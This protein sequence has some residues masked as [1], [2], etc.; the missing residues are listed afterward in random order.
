MDG[1]GEGRLVLLSSEVNRTVESVKFDPIDQASLLSH[2]RELFWVGNDGLHTWEDSVL[3]TYP[4]LPVDGSLY[5][6]HRTDSGYLAAINGGAPQ[7]DSYVSGLILLENEMKREWTHPGWLHSIAWVAGTVV[8]LTSPNLDDPMVTLTDLGPGDSRGRALGDAIDSSSVWGQLTRDGNR[9]M[10][11][12]TRAMAG[13]AAE[14]LIVDVVSGS[15]IKH[16]LGGA[17]ASFDVADWYAGSGPSNPILHEGQLLWITG[18]TLWRT[19]PAS[20]DTQR[21]YDVVKSNST[22]GVAHYLSSNGL[23]STW[24]TEAGWNLEMRHLSSG[25]VI[26]TMQGI[27]VDGPPDLYVMGAVFLG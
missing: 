24:R 6:L 21:V 17:G 15:T 19:D 22:S 23:L 14:L 7:A 27:T 9:V 25:E 4:G 26:D 5:E 16:P 11:F 13:A 10:V 1:S 20:G 8:G 3:H 12:T 18:D 2:G